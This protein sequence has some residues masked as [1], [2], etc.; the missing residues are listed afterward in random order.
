MATK[1]K[2]A[3]PTPATTR[4]GQID[5]LLLP[6]PGV[7]GKKMASLDAYFVNDRMFA[8]ISGKG[9]GIRLPVAVATELQFS[10]A[11]V[12]PF[13]PGGTASSREWIQVNRENAGEYA[14][15]LELFKA[16]I[17]FVKGGR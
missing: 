7:V 2:A 14:Q 17:D 5:A 4:K 3:A 6:L 10:R 11:D 15:D 1:K 16:S 9:I 13:Q 8:C 12:E